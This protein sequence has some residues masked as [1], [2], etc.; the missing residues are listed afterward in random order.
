[1]I[2]HRST[3]SALAFALAAAAASGFA[4]LTFTA[5]ASATAVTSVHS[6]VDTKA[7]TTINLATDPRSDKEDRPT[8]AIDSAF[9]GDPE[10]PKRQPV[11]F[12]GV[13]RDDRVAIRDPRTMPQWHDLTSLLPRDFGRLVDI[14]LAAPDEGDTVHITVLNER[15]KVAQS[16]CTVFPTPGTK[17]TPEWPDNCTDF[18]DLTRR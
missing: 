12:V 6:V 10:D 9:Q 18:I 8:R 13:I 15:G 3:R 16:R 17:G 7:A 14:T 5:S 1:M 4:T 11:K 2:N